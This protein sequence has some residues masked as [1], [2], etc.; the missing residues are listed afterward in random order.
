MRTQYITILMIAIFCWPAVAVIH[1]D[2]PLQVENQNIMRASVGQLGQGSERLSTVF[3]RALYNAGLPGGIVS[4]R[5]IEQR[6]DLQ[7]LSNSTLGNLLTIITNVE[8][9]YRWE[10]SNG[11]INLLPVDS[12]PQLLDFMVPEFT[13]SNATSLYSALNSLLSQPEVVKRVVELNLNKG[14]SVFVGPVEMPNLKADAK[15]FSVS[16]KNKTLRE[17]LN[18]IVL[19]HGRGV[20]EYKATQWKDTHGFTISFLNQ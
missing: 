7:S 17:V 18:A 13:T 9:R 2:K 20:W 14:L 5:A 12:Y 6:I 1:A 15:K 10:T 16:L 19:A 3:T 4:T 11:V 8:P